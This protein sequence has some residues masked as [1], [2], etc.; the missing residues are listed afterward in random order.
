M[1]QANPFVTSPTS[2]ALTNDNTLTIGTIDEIQKLHIRTVSLGETP[3]LVADICW[4]EMVPLFA[5][6][7]QLNSMLNKHFQFF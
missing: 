3:R 4:I 2:L 5:V 6:S 1:E 7:C